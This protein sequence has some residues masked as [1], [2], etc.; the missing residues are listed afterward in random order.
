MS[1]SSDRPIPTIT[2]ASTPT[3]SVAAIAATATQKSKRWTL[4]RPGTRAG[5]IVQR[6]GRQTGRDGH[7]LEQPSADIRH[8]LGDRL[9]VDVDA[10][11]VPGRERPRVAGGLENPMSTSATAAIATVLG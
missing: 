5:V 10:I 1:Q 9:L 2:P 4:A 8:A 6:A 3:S 11:A 7:S